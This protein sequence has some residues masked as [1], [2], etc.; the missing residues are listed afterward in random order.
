MRA[1][2]QRNN[3]D[4][5]R[6]WNTF[7]PRLGWTALITVIVAG[8][9]AFALAQSGQAQAAGIV[10]VLLALSLGM[11]FVAWVLR[12]LLVGRRRRRDR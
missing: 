3:K 7:A 6:S 8:V 1:R 9:A 4:H 12:F 5:D 11:A 10:T 2:N